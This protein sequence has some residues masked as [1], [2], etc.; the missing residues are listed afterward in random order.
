KREGTGYDEDDL[1][2]A[3]L[4]G[5]V[6]ELGLVPEDFRRYLAAVEALVREEIALVRCRPD[7]PKERAQDPRL[8]AI[9]EELPR[10]LYRK[11]QLKV[12]EQLKDQGFFEEKMK[13]FRE[14]YQKGTE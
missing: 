4:L 6:F 2:I 10:Y 1:R 12:F 13:R 14:R 8:T 11:T 9:A 3:E 5:P 7:I